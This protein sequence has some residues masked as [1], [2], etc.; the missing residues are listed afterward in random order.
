MKQS[1]R[2]LEPL[3]TPYVDGE[4]SADQCAAVETHL[5]KCPT[6]RDCADALVHVR[7]LVHEC[8]DELH[9]HAPPALHARCAQLAR[10][11]AASPA[12]ARAAGAGSSA[13]SP[14]SD[15]GLAA[16]AFAGARAAAASG[17][18]RRWAAPLSLAA[19]LLLVVAG[20]LLYGQVAQRSTAYASQLA[21]DHVRCMRLF[22]TQKPSDSAEQATLWQR[23]RGW[24]VPLPASSPADQIEFVML[25]RCLSTQGTVAHALYRHQG[26]LVSLYIAQRG[27]QRADVQQVMG[28]QTCVWN[29]DGYSFAVVG[30]E[31]PEDMARLVTWFRRRLDV[32]RKEE[33][34]DR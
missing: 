25:R 20:I 19:T 8:R 11:M 21:Q 23:T 2:D 4:A 12:G 3:L 28:Q 34:N 30:A 6:C 9:D 26:Q 29:Q 24:R 32:N 14:S 7:Q 10:E 27:D 22:G 16:G 31:S 18:W 5:S 33:E 15:A 13:S 1:C 17:G